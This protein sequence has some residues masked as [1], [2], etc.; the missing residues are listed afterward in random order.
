MKCFVIGLVLLTF[1]FLSGLGVGRNLP[2]P[3]LSQPVLRD[4]VQHQ[5]YLN[6]LRALD[7]DSPYPALKVD[8]KMGAKTVELWEWLSAH[9]YGVEK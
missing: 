7:P 1:C 8:G 5:E 3:A 6:E 4:I 9:Y 2:S